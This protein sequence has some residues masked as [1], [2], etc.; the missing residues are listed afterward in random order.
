MQAKST[1]SIRKGASNCKFSAG[2]RAGGSKVC[3]TATTA[4]RNSQQ[5]QILTLSHYPLFFSSDT[6]TDIPPED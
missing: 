3:T 2:G 6:R 5:N 4:R 1:Y